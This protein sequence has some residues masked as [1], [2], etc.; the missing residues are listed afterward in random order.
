MIRIR[1]RQ[2]PG[3]LRCL[4]MCRSGTVQSFTPEAA[5]AS[6]IGGNGIVAVELP[7][8]VEQVGHL[9]AAERFTEQGEQIGTEFRAAIILRL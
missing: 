4:D 5:S 1:D 2:Q 3:N 7:L 9:A 8:A 6:D